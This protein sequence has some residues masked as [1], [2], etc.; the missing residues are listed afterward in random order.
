MKIWISTVVNYKSTLKNRKTAKI[1]TITLEQ[2]ISGKLW[3]VNVYKQALEA[4]QN[5][6]TKLFSFQI[7]VA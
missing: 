1:I 2:L 4:I 7:Q 3:K 6:I 5:M